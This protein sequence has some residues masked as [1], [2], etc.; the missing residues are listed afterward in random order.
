MTT[1]PRF[2]LTSINV[3]NESGVVTFHGSDPG[4]NGNS[5]LILTDIAP[6]PEPDSS[7]IY[8][9]SI[10]SPTEFKELVR[11]EKKHVLLC[12]HGF[13]TKPSD[14]LKSCANYTGN[15]LVIPVIWPSDARGL[16]TYWTDKS[17]IQDEVA[18]QLQ[19]LF[20]IIN[21]ALGPNKSIMCHSMGNYVLQ[22]L[23][24]S[25]PGM[26]PIAT[27]RDIFMVAAD[28]GRDIF[29]KGKVHGTSVLHLSSN[30]IVVLYSRRDLAMYARLF[31][32]WF[33][34]ALGH[35]GCD[36][37]RIVEDQRQKV[38]NIESS[39]FQACCSAGTGHGYQFTA[40]AIGIYE[41]PLSPPTEP[42]EVIS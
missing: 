30:R 27:F 40:R 8:T 10:K 9:A 7:D 18:A 3:T 34:C 33:K 13:N 28:V 36:T 32:N 12:V 19:V 35:A 5:A 42:P 15:Y 23:A 20:H 14:W 21:D 4:V 2:M 24:P 25:A 39:S 41:N 16:C 17:N 38:I 11:A 31:T 26:P 6:S 22:I 1:L 37:T 29:D